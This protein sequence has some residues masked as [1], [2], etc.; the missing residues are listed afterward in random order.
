ML[1]KQHSS[2]QARLII[3]KYYE[4]NKDIFSPKE[5]FV[6]IFRASDATKYSKNLYRI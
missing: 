2:A 5:P 6:V 4:N 3:K 1:Q